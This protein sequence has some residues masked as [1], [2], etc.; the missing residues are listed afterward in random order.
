MAYANGQMPLS[1]MEAVRSEYFIPEAARQLR[2]LEAAFARHFGHEFIINEGYRTLATQQRLYN[3]WVKRLPGYFLAARPGTS[4]HGW[5][6]AGDFGSGINQYGTAQK[7]WMDTN[8]PAYGWKPTGNGFSPREAWH[9]DYVGN[10]AILAGTGG[11]GATIP[12]P[13]TIPEP[14][15]ELNM[16]DIRYY[17]KEEGGKEGMILGRTLP[18]GWR[19]VDAATPEGLLQAEAWGV[20]FGRTD[21]DRAGAPYGTLPQGRWRK[22]QETAAALNAEWLAEQKALA[23]TAAVVDFDYTKLAAALS[24]VIPAAP[25]TAGILAALGRLPGETAEAVRERIIAP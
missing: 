20:L 22:A 15:E 10:P 24:G 2:A 11:A 3:G 16:D 18:G 5:G 14:L 21:E 8:A 23:G 13:P 4:N 17:W 6:K 12:T 7:K 19:A 25:S 1:I 9:F